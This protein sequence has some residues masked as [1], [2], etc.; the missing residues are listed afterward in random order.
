MKQS[1]F[2]KKLYDW[3]IEP[4]KQ[5]ASLEYG[6]G[7]P[8]NKMI[9]GFYPVYGS[10]GIVG[11]HNN[12]LVKGPGIVI[13]RKGT[14]GAVTYVNEDFWPIDTTY[15]IRLKSDEVD[16]R[17]LFYRLQML[18][19]QALNMA[20]GV[21][22][23][24]RNLVYSLSVKWPNRIEQSKIG[25][26]LYTVDEA[27]D[28][29]EALIQ[30]YER[31]KRGLVQDLLTKGIDENG[32]IRDEKTHKFKGS[33]LG[34]IPEEWEV[35]TIK[36]FASD[37]K[38]AIVDGPFGSNLKTEH[39]RSS[40]R[41]I[42]QSG[43]VTSG[44]FSA[45]SYLFVDEDKFRSEIRSKVEP[46]D[47]VM[48]KIGA[49]CGT[50]SIMPEGHPVGILAGNCLKITVGKNNFNKYL[51]LLLQYYYKI[52][53]L[54]LIISTTAQPAVNMQLLKQIFVPR[55]PLAEQKRIVAFS[56]T[57]AGCVE[58]EDTYRQKLLAIKLGLMQD[59]LTGTV[60]V[61]NLIESN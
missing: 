13:G 33:P 50:C 49:Q 27:I 2:D 41:P 40:G 26:I 7:L 3:K 23:L 51:E 45:E 22:G 1:C 37:K 9:S 59:L 5:K 38:F 53:K 17:W 52:G 29:T 12:Y 35:V 4:F 18:N 8:E 14:A 16:L 39:Y 30:K 24:N 11:F 25:E 58:K 19:L 43:F 57:M 31:I 36:Q 60:R 15:F 28:D 21:P 20:T 34:R 48:A 10:N 6:S 42:I 61:N 55:P 44:K 56:D 47:I 32:N 54:F 46:G